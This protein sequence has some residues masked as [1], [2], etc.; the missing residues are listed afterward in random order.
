MYEVRQ[1]SDASATYSAHRHLSVILTPP[2]LLLGLLQQL[3][4]CSSH[5]ETTIRGIYRAMVYHVLQQAFLY[6]AQ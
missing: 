1:W 2:F 5:I 6:V 3:C 4:H